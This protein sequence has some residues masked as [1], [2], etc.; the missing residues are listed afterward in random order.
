MLRSDRPDAI[1]C[2]IFS[3]LDIAQF[4][5]H[6][7]AKKPN[8]INLENHGNQSHAVAIARVRASDLPA[9]LISR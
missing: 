3:Y 6:R 8:Q 7:A 5:Y 9:N 4:D 1:R 2:Q